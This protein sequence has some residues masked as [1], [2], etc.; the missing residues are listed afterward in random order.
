MQASHRGPDNPALGHAAERTDALRLPLLAVFGLDAAYSEA[1]LRHFAFLLEGLA[2]ARRDL[3]GRGIR[4][5]ATAA[6]RQPRGPRK[7]SLGIRIPDNVRA[8]DDRLLDA[9]DP[10][11]FAG[12]AWVFGTHDRAWPERQIF[13]KIRCMN[14]PGSRRKFDADGWAAGVPA[15]DAPGAGD[16]AAG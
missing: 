5:A 7:D 9:R 15:L 10:N 4:L 6:A 3:A 14:D 13:G 16:P 11:S 2:A 1:N 12:V 8:L